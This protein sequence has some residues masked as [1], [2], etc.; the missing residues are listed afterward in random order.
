[1]TGRKSITLSLSVDSVE[2]LKRVGAA[3]FEEPP[4]EPLFPY[5]DGNCLARHEGTVVSR[6]RKRRGRCIG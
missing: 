1:M 2:Q 5:T 6:L 3:F 4:K